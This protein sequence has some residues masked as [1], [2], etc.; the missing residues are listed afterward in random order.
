[1]K[2]CQ[3]GG[4]AHRRT[5]VVDQVSRE[6]RSWNMGRIR[7]DDTRPELEVRSMLHR[8]GYRFRLH[9]QDL[10][11]KPDIILP[12]HRTVVF[13]HGCFWHQH[14]GCRRAN[15]P[16]SNKQYWTVKLERNTRRDRVNIRSL[17]KLGWRVLVVWEC[18]LKNPERLRHRLAR[19]L[20]R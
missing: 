18:E 14:P 2:A 5:S 7:S 17:R 4:S 8:M 19:S 20:S 10:P 3:S 6:R 13:V 1:M 15:V 9:A 11:G 12:R 16:K